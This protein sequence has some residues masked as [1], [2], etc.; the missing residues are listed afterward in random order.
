M[1]K[2]SVVN[3]R[4]WVPLKAVRGSTAVWL[5]WCSPSRRIFFSGVAE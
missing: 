4:A 2:Y 1:R 3:Q 5:S